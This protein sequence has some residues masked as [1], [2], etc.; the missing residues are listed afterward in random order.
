MMNPYQQYVYNMST[1]ALGLSSVNDL[2][3]LS[4]N[5]QMNIYEGYHNVFHALHVSCNAQLIANKLGGF[6]DSQI[7]SLVVAGLYHDAGH[8]LG[9]SSESDNIKRAIEMFCESSFASTCAQDDFDPVLLIKATEFP[10]MRDKV[11]LDGS[12]AQKI[13]IDADLSVVACPKELHPY[14]YQGLLDE[15][16]DSLPPAQFIGQ[17]GVV[18]KETRGLFRDILN[19][20]VPLARK[21]VN[22]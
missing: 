8:S 12:I 16:V 1:D 15:G 20:D 19:L 10:S 17:V 22:G 3:I 4:E 18:F 7:W 11:I 6:S 21:V 2:D 5:L 13:M 9:R 14:L